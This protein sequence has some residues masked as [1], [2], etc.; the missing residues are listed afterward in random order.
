[1]RR[2]LMA[3]VA[4]MLAATGLL[5]PTGAG[6]EAGQADVVRLDGVR[7]ELRSLVQL[8]DAARVPVIGVGR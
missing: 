6:A 8:L 5:A 4:A 7:V 1:M 2:L 3:A